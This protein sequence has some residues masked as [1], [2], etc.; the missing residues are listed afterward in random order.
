VAGADVHLNR[1]SGFPQ[2]RQQRH[3]D[4]LI[5]AAIRRH[6]FYQQQEPYFS[7]FMRLMDDLGNP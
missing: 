6:N 3:P 4:A 7:N 1:D 2:S 5:Q